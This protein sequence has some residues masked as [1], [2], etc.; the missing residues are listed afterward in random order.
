M[1]QTNSTRFISPTHGPGLAGFKT[2]PVDGSIGLHGGDGSM[3]HFSLVAKL[4]WSGRLAEF[5]KDYIPILQV[6]GNVLPLRSS[7]A[8]LL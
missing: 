3:T 6:L 8:R 7:L 4:G 5:C 2:Q 1:D